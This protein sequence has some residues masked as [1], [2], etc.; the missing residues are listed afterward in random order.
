[1]KLSTLCCKIGHAWI[2]YAWFGR[3]AYQ[4]CK[5][6]DAMRAYKVAA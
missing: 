5:R 6:C 4:R 2:T 1:M 3:L